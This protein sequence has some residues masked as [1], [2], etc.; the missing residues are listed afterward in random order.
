[1]G[2]IFTLATK[3]YVTSLLILWL[4]LLSGCLPA[5]AQAPEI[6]GVLPAGGQRGTKVA[7]R[8]DGKNLQGAKALLSG[9]GI[10]VESVDANS[11]GDRATLHL[12]ISADAPLGP[13]E[14]RLGTLKG[15]SNL[16]HL[17]VDV[18]PD[19]LEV[20]PN[21]DPAHAQKLERAP[22][23]VDGHM[24]A[25][26]DRD[27]F[28]FQARAGETW[29]FDCNAARLHSRLDPILELRD[30][31]GH[32]LQ[33][34]QSFWERDPRLLH[35]FAKSGAYF[36]TVRDSQFLG[37]PDYVY[38]LTA[39]PLPVLTGILPHGL[40]AGHT[41]SFRISG[42]NLGG[43]AETILSLPG[44]VGPGEWWTSVPT[45]GGMTLPFPLLVADT[46]V[47]AVSESETPLRLSTLPLSLDG[48]F[49]RYPHRRFSFHAAPT[50][51]IVF[52]LLGRRIGS[53]ID[54]ALRILDSA[55]KELASSD[56]AIGKDARLEFSATTAGD[57]LVEARNVEEKLGP[58]CFYRLVVRHP[59]PD[60]R[61]MLNTSR[62]HVGAGGTSAVTVV[63]TPAEGFAAPITVRAEGLPPGVACSGGTIL[64]GQSSVEITLTAAA[65]MPLGASE[66]HLRGS[67]A[68]GGKS[69]VHAVTPREPYLPRAIDPGMFTDDSYRNPYRDED[70]L[71][72]GVI[73]RSE[74]FAL[75]MSSSTVALA[76]GQKAD[77][78]VR[79]VRQIGANAEIKIEVRGL[80]E[81]VT[82]VV[83]PIAANQTETHL[84]LTAGPD[85]K[86]TLRNLIVQGR[87]GNSIQPAPAIHLTVT[88]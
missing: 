51:P 59:R 8:I 29:V 87:Q 49:E 57:Y 50:E 6:A 34:A 14:V 5:G 54:G 64:P 13:R 81:K 11:A 25:P 31:G 23:V 38:R 58:D 18:F 36:L 33:M 79:A 41:A 26:T 19:V 67:A 1:V 3:T 46:P 60:F 55:G 62:I 69:V 35:R 30:E 27:V 65:N 4:G 75:E 52:D 2:A 63:A 47:S 17:W 71:A 73:E 44:D 61:V 83:A 20:E 80:P 82:A 66:I 70:L 53:R 7:I 32:M 16:I 21:D 24:Q 86:P 76:S 40:Q 72:L 9:Q 85:V 88:P 45:A 78:T 77:I 22:V 43:T 39:G 28:T 37:G 84:V 48:A 42:N 56:D 74:P 68:I 12:A 15:V 10:K